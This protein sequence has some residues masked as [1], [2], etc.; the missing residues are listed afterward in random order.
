MIPYSRLLAAGSAI[1]TVAFLQI[2]TL[3]YLAAFPLAY[4]T[5]W[6]GL[7]RPPKIPFGDLSYGLFLFHVPMEQTVMHL[8][9]GLRHHW[10]L[11]S[12]IS[13]PL[14]L[15][16]AWLSWNLVEKRFLKH[17]KLFLAKADAAYG[18]VHQLLSGTSSSDISRTLPCSRKKNRL[19]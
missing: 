13:L 14:T 6:L 7:T 11:L 17:K 16:Y 9:P 19:Q 12:L 18:A 3:T 5:V 4:L 8:F 15:A 10:W 1:L 2:P